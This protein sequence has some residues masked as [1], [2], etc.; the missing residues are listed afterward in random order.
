MRGLARLSGRDWIALA[1]EV[2]AIAILAVGLLSADRFAA[3]VLA[4]LAHV[5]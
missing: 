5:P 4:L 1:I 3:F 2:G